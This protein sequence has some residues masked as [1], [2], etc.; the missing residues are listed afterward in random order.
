LTLE[1][2]AGAV[3]AG[4]MGPFATEEMSVAFVFDAEDARDIAARSP[5]SDPDAAMPDTVEG[6]ARDGLTG[7]R[8]IDAGDAL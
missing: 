5:G 8:T 6:I 1:D 2:V 3:L 7:T 4:S